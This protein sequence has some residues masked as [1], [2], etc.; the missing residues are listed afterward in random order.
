MRWYHSEMQID[1]NDQKYIIINA[2]LIKSVQ[3]C[4]PLQFFFLPEAQRRYI[5]LAFMYVFLQCVLALLDLILLL[6]LL[7]G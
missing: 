2:V 7:L 6:E 3:Y 1:V 4:A 5:Y